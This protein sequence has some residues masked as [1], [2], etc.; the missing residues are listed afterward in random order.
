MGTAGV[1]PPEGVWSGERGRDPHLTPPPNGRFRPRKG[2]RCSR[3]STEPPTVR[4]PHPPP[5]P[6]VCLC[7]CNSPPRGEPEAAE[8]G[9]GAFAS[10]SR[11]GLKIQPRPKLDRSGHFERFHR[12]L[13]RAV[14]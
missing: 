14:D 6:F 7:L 4:T 5:T 11:G 2:V 1:S 12:I 8:G 9:G 13:F 10:A 3:T